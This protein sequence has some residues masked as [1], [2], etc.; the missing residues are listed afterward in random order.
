[1]VFSPKQ[2]YILKHYAIYNPLHIINHGAVRS[3]KT[4]INNLIWINHVYKFKRKDFI[5]TG[6][7]ISS[8]ERNILKPLYDDYGLDTHLNIRNNFNL[9]TNKIHCFGAD[10]SDSFKAMTGMTSYGWYGNEITLQHPNTINES[11]DRTSGEGFSIL[12]D[13]NP[14]YPHHPIKINYINKTGEKMENGRLRI[15]AHHFELE[16]NIHLDPVYIENL[17][18]STPRGMWYDRRI[19]GLWV[20]AEG[21]VFPN[22]YRHTHVIEP[23]RIPDDWQRIR[24]IDWGF[25]NPFTC[26]WFAVD[27][28]GRMY[29]YHEYKKANT[30]LKDHARYINNFV[31]L[32][33]TKV[34]IVADRT[35]ADHDPQDAAEM[36][37]HGIYSQPAIKDDKRYSIQKLAE[38]M[39]IQPDGK[40]RFMIFNTCTEAI[41]EF[42]Q[43]VWQPKKEGQPYK[44]EPIKENDHIIDPT[45]YVCRALDKGEILIPDYSV[46]DLGL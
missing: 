38:R 34:P 28:D 27:N 22:F 30:L 2:E 13:T 23:F 6:H 42:E 31:E 45:L 21:L 19:K 12:W 3:G 32:S 37:E 14:D 20:A 9:F 33:K 40:P 41:K 46:G 5:I 8:I 10:K 39:V 43:Y 1:M 18:K 11:F 4:W 26:V 35:I 44:E 29:M 24:G 25:Q 15:K 36:V 17:K 16:D 7:T